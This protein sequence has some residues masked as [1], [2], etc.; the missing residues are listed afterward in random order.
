[1]SVQS[2]EI[3]DICLDCRQLRE[4]KFTEL[5]NL[6]ELYCRNCPLITE[7]PKELVNLEVLDCH[8]C[9]QITEIP[10]VFVNLQQLYCHHCPQ[11]TEIPNV[12]VN[13]Q[14][15]YCHDC[16]GITGIPKELV[17]LQTLDC[18]GCPLITEIKFVN[19][20]LLYCSGCPLI[21][22]I[23]LVNLQL[24]FCSGCPL[25]TEIELNDLEW[26]CCNDSVYLPYDLHQ[27]F[28]PGKP[29]IP[30]P[31]YDGIMREA[32]A[33]HKLDQHLPVLQR[34]FIQRMYHPDSRYVNEVIKPR[35]E[36]QQ[37][38]IMQDKLKIILK[39]QDCPQ[40]TEIKF[41]ILNLILSIDL[42]SS[43]KP[44]ATPISTSTCND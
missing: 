16:P 21:T 25:I 31:S 37:R 39:T 28:R 24:L 29:M 22:E 33:Y 4:I 8:H 3:E 5:V 34:R 27:R 14:A 13:L 30:H 40:I 36:K 2:D 35:F 18:S 38:L 10:N 6:R 9:P 17:N 20:Q 44:N 11:I 43:G 26:L 19:L 1:M 42:H 7:I 15:L 23:R 41:A 32:N 12:F